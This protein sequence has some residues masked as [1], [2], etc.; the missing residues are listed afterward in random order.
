MPESGLKINEVQCPRT[1]VWLDLKP[2]YSDWTGLAIRSFQPNGTSHNAHFFGSN[3]T[4]RPSIPF[5]RGLMPIDSDL[6]NKA[7]CPFTEIPWQGS[8]PA[9]SD[10]IA[11]DTRPFGSN[12]GTGHSRHSWLSQ[13]PVDGSSPFAD[14]R[15]PARTLNLIQR[16]TDPNANW[17]HVR[18]AFGPSWLHW[19]GAMVFTF[20]SHFSQEKVEKR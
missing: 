10:L 2:V 19:S 8:T 6:H 1:L 7:R 17:P 14:V 4:W 15:G 18:F 5:Y 20:P 9:Y 12:L 11:L 13:G 16:L 3:G